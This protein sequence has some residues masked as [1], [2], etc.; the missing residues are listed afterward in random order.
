MS[1]I[2]KIVR[3]KNLV[4]FDRGSFDEW[5]VFLS[6]PGTVR[7]AP[8]D[9]EYFTILKNMGNHFGH[10][11]IYNDFISYY[12]QTTKDI[13]NTILD[14]I[15]TLSNDYENEAEEMDTWFTVIYAG[16]IAEENKAN[17]KLKKRIKRLGMHQ[18]LLENFDPELAANFSKGK[19]WP[20]LDKLMKEKGF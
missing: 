17:T 18:V 14:L 3:G 20:E 5:C 4:E 2:I 10:A 1:R 16:M 15:T 12:N 11:K 8:K 9:T 13:D 6:R 7:Y 19:N